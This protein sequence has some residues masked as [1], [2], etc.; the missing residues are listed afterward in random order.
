MYKL[1]VINNFYEKIDSNPC[2]NPILM[3]V[4]ERGGVMLDSIQLDFFL[5]FVSMARMRMNKF[6]TCHSTSFPFPSSRLI[7][8]ESQKCEERENFGFYGFS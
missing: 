8:L 7:L 2:I 5:D 1:H 4:I 6:F 3:P